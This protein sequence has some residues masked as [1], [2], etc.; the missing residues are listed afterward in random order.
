MVE[1]SFHASI[2]LNIH[3]EAVFLRRTLLSL[4]EAVQFAGSKV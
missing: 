3:R 1:I 2:I 4:A